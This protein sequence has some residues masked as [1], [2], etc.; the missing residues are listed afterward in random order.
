MTLTLAHSTEKTLNMSTRIQEVAVE[1]KVAAVLASQMCV[2]HYKRLT[3]AFSTNCTKVFEVFAVRQYLLY[4][5]V[6]FVR[7]R[8]LLCLACH[9]L[10]FWPV[11][12]F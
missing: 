5:F 2:E 10:A 11:L 3:C 9:R 8:E 4:L 12:E 1:V 7:L 6:I